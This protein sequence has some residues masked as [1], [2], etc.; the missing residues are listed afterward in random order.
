MTSPAF[1]FS[2]A[3][4]WL[5]LCLYLACAN[6]ETASIAAN[7]TNARA[8][9]GAAG[10]PGIGR[11]GSGGMAGFGGTGSGGMA[12]FAGTGSGGMAGF[13]GASPVPAERQ[14]LA[15]LPR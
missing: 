8:I 5:P 6:Q 7:G 13:G 12:G 9:H 11:A 4:R 10:A 1:S 2:P 14:A 15:L 3:L